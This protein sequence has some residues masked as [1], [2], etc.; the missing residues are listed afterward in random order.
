MSESRLLPSSADA[1]LKRIDI[2]AKISFTKII[3]NCRDQEGI[4]EELNK[5][6]IKI[7]NNNFQSMEFMAL[8][9]IKQVLK[10][11]TD[12]SI[13]RQSGDWSISWD[14]MHYLLSDAGKNKEFVSQF[15]EGIQ[16]IGYDGICKYERYIPSKPPHRIWIAFKPNQIKSVNNN[17]DFGTEN[18]NIYKSFLISD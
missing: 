9:R 6:G 1:I 8:L 17:G 15:N 2:K 13:F 12:N 3:S 11:R 5:S 4:V 16:K 14:E 7:D 10:T 18:N